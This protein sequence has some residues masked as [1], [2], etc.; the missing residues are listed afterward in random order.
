MT[1]GTLVIGRNDGAN[2]AGNLVVSQ[3]IA[4][5]NT[6]TLIRLYPELYHVAAD[7]AWP[8][9]ERVSTC[10]KRVASRSYFE[11]RRDLLLLLRAPG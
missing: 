3:A 10:A 4:P 11:L 9:I 8:A 7:G 6:D 2:A 1:A 5:A